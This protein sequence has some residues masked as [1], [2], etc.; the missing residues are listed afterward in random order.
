[1]LVGQIGNKLII[2]LVIFTVNLLQNNIIHVFLV[3]VI[4]FSQTRVYHGRVSLAHRQKLLVLLPWKPINA[5][6]SIT[7]QQGKNMQAKRGLELFMKTC[8][9]SLKRSVTCQ[10]RCHFAFDC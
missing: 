1:M 4:Y 9:I 7:Y 3:G 5:D 6:K 8:A 2:R 10:A